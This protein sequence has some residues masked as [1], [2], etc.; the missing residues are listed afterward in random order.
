MRLVARVQEGGS[1]S[2][3][4]IKEL[5]DDGEA[6]FSIGSQEVLG[7]CVCLKPRWS[8]SCV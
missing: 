8:H 4:S 1:D 5:K 7:E 2:K 6:K 3:P